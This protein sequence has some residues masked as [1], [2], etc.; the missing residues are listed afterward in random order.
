MLFFIIGG[1]VIYKNM[2]KEPKNII[3]G[4]FLPEGKDAKEM[5]A[6]ELKKAAEHEID[7]SNFTLSIYPEAI[8]ETSDDKGK[9][10]IRNEPTNVYPI[11]VEIV[12]DKTQEIIYKSGAIQPGYEITEGKLSKKLGKGTYKCTANVS[13][14][15]PKTKKYRGQTAAEMTVEVKN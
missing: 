11:A 12:E 5:N 6:E 14:F 15:D 3:A 13:I 7:A 4:T 8:F 2:K 1:G 9:L 10:F